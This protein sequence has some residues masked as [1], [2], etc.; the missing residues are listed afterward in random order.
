MDNVFVLYDRATESVWYPGDEENLEAVAGAAQGTSIT[1]LD[2]PDPQPLSTWVQEHPDSVVL[3]PSEADWKAGKRPRVGLRF[4]DREDALEVRRVVDGGP[5]AK[6]GI[7]KGDLIL[8][9]GGREI[10]NA[11]QLQALLD[12]YAGG[13]ELDVVFM[14]EGK[15]I[16]AK[17]TLISPSG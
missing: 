2:E 17:L 13:D 10:A 12:E 6:A 14:R 3:V 4:T 8:R 16:A 1:F 9:L 15:E 7:V 5:A 11:E